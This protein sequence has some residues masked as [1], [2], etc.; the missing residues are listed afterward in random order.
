MAWAKLSTILEPENLTAA[1]MASIPSMVPLGQPKRP[2]RRRHCPTGRFPDQQLR[3][4]AGPAPDLRSGPF[5]RTHS[6]SSVDRRRRRQDHSQFV[7]QN[8]QLLIS[9]LFL[10]FDLYEPTKVALEQMVPRMPKGAV[11]AFDELDNPIWPGET[12][13][14]SNFAGGAPANP[15]RG[16][17]SLHWLRRPGL[18]QVPS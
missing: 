8:S 2:Q 4:I 13:A 15:A 1:S 18:K 11:L 14:C 6:Q 10:D 16:M 7:Q 17:G 9:L 3:R 5:S 12:Q